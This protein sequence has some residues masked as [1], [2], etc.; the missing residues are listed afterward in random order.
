M[1]HSPGIAYTRGIWCIWE[2][3]SRAWYI[4]RWS[5]LTMSTPLRESNHQ[6]TQEC[7]RVACHPRLAYPSIAHSLAPSFARPLKCFVPCVCSQGEWD[8]RW[9]VLVVGSC[10][11]HHS[12]HPNPAWYFEEGCGSRGVPERKALAEAW[13]SLL[14]RCYG[15]LKLRSPLHIGLLL[16][17]YYIRT[18]PEPSSHMEILVCCV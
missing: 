3:F 14:W 18:H 8:R 16:S 7:Y 15:Q 1:R 12:S 6:C 17:R 5:P 2:S 9:G 11:L 13:P 10:R 4:S